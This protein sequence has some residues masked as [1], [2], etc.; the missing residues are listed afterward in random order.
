MNYSQDI[1]D[2]YEKNI[3]S[4]LRKIKK[5]LNKEHKIIA[6]GIVQYDFNDFEDL[7]TPP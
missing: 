7:S 3:Q 2:R 1:L 6:P 5:S 4:R